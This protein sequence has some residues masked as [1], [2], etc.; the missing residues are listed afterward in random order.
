MASRLDMLRF[1]LGRL[2]KPGMLG[3]LLL[4]VSLI[5][6]AAVVRPKEAAL[7]DLAVHKEQARKAQAA[8]QAKA[9]DQDMAASLR[10]PLAPEAPAAF[11]HLYEA[12]NESGLEL[13]Q[14]EYR[15]ALGKDV[16]IPHYQFL[17]P[18]YGNYADVRH[19]L[20]LAL[21]NEPALALTSVQ[22][23]REEIEETEL[24]VAL[25][26]TLYLGTAP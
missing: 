5:F 22:M 10:T 6:L 21:N 3:L 26:F 19:F 16:G 20:G 14:G 11:R 8:A 23:R 18:V 17:L 13:V 1:H 24:D 15:L 9:A 12:A 4:L 2:G 7:A 25:S